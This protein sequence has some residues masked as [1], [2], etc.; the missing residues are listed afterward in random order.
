MSGVNSPGNLTAFPLPTFHPQQNQVW[1]DS[2]LKKP[3]FNLEN[4]KK[5][6]LIYAPIRK[7]L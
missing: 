7:Q 3:N 4:L 1:P 2:F 5:V 6:V